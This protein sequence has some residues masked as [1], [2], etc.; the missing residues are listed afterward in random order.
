LKKPDCKHLINPP[1]GM[2]EIIRKKKAERGKTE[3]GK[4]WKKG[5][6]M[7]GNVQCPG[8]TRMALT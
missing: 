6:L 5:M 3:E 4:G 7:Q 2:L 8:L 1:Q